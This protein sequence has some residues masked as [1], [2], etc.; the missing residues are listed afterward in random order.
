MTA[1][2]PLA[3]PGGPTLPNQ[4]T[5]LVFLLGL[6][7]PL[8]IGLQI[9]AIA[10][11]HS[12]GRVSLGENLSGPAIAG[13]LA[14]LVAG[15]CWAG[16]RQFFA[17]TTAP[18][19]PWQPVSSALVILL[20]AAPLAAVAVQALSLALVRHPIV[21]PEPGSLFDRMGLSASYGLPILA[22]ALAILGYAIAERSSL[23]A[24][25]A[26][27]LGNAAATTAYLL[28]LPVGALVFDRHQWIRLAQLN[29]IVAAGCALAWLAAL[30]WSR[31]NRQPREPL[32][33]DFPCVT[34]LVLAP[35]LVLLLL[36]WAWCE[37]VV[38]PQG[39]SPQS[40]VVD[41]ELV[42]AWGW[43]SAA[44]AVAVGAVALWNA[45][46]RASVAG[47]SV[48]L[49][50]LAVMAAAI[51]A[52]WDIGNWL[53]YRTLLVGHA[54][55]VAV[56]VAIAWQAR[57][58]SSSGVAMGTLTSRLAG[59]ENSLWASLARVIVLLLAIRELPDDRWW[60]AGALLVL[61]ASGA[62]LAWIFQRRRHLYDAAL[63]LSAGRVNRA[64]RIEV[65]AR[66]V[67]LCLCQRRAVGRAGGNL[68]GDREIQHQ[69]TDVDL[70]NRIRAGPSSRH[71][72]GSVDPGRRDRA[73]AVCRR[74]SALLWRSRYL[75]A[76]GCAGISRA[77][78]DGL[79][80][81]HCRA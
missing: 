51:A 12:P 64:G 49:V 71:A 37:L 66:R 34:Q 5:T 72:L 2:L 77:G 68:A 69:P 61:A 42:D 55:M 27:L 40:P 6:I 62:A 76:L 63:M 65:S 44:L 15:M 26:G 81:G 33:F 47:L 21:G 31:R 1:R 32:T 79:P 57:R 35:A 29:T 41:P 78:R 59:T 54:T 75:D 9:A 45:G 73:L 7:A 11:G 10:L 8:A 48:C 52:R 28:Y 67:E 19:S 18:R 74:Q 39:W 17:R 50:G 38:Y 20:G 30:A 56:L 58:E 13:T 80:V 25:G 53:A 16:A 70:A 22:L 14:L 3:T 43:L 4:A 46:I 36:G 60:P 24:L 23:L